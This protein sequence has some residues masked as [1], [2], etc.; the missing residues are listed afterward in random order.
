MRSEENKPYD[1]T[2]GVFMPAYNHGE[3]V[4]EAIQSLK[5][6]T[7]QDFVVHIVDDGSNDGKT[8]KK[9]KAVKY[10]KAKLFLNSDN[11]GV[12]FRA[13][14]HFKMLNTKYVLVLCA[15]DLLA[16]EFLEKTVNFLEKH[17]DYGAVSVNIKFFENSIN[18][19]YA[20]QKFNAELMKLPIVLARNQ[21]LGSSLMRKQALDETDLSGGFVRY[22]DWDRWI[23]MMEAGWKIG[24]VSEFL[25]FY[26]QLPNSLSHSAS[27]NDEFE[28]RKK[29]LKK[30]AK[31][32][33]KY[34]N[35]V[36]LNMEYAFLEMQE[37]KNWLDGQYKILNREIGRLNGIINKLEKESKVKKSLKKF[38]RRIIRRKSKNGV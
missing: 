13:R 29:L 30:H 25:F 19:C 38:I 6:Q 4:E 9:L 24:L 21:I 34:Y 32:Y 18:E 3:Y 36:I 35:E 28:I 8:P 14:Q 27:L 26:R 23:S 10:D 16:P 33:E 22:Q 31:S 12:A 2:V 7:F 5:A 15:D 17:V 1:A 37:G 11:K 20:E